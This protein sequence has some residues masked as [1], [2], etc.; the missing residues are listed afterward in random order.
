MRRASENSSASSGK[1]SVAT[2]RTRDSSSPRIIYRRR[3]V[4]SDCG[5]SP[6]L[7]MP[8][9]NG[10]NES[11]NELLTFE[12]FTRY[13]NENV[14]IQITDVRTKLE[15]VTKQVDGNAM[16]IRSIQDE[17]C[18]LKSGRPPPGLACPARV[19][20]ADAERYDKSR[21]SLRVWPIPG[22]DSAKI[23]ESSGVFIHS[24]LRVPQDEMDDSKIQEIKRIRHAG[25]KFK[26]EALIVFVDLESRDVVASYARNLSDRVDSAGNPTA[27][28]RIDIPSHLMGTFKLLENH[29]RQLRERYGPDF[30]RHVR[31]GDT[32]KSLF[33]NI[34]L[35]SDQVWTR[36]S[37]AF[38]RSIAS[39]YESSHEARSKYGPRA[40]SSASSNST[41]PIIYGA[42]LRRPRTDH[43]R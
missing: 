11:D 22:S 10:D 8:A 24:T 37:P 27:G 30:K 34:R 6:A 15:D 32:E 16:D 43:P 20:Y 17:L 31:F 2:K 33:L 5:A 41:T 9:V 1:R 13:M 18:K 7:K 39:E 19:G 28:L 42:S 36:I 21:R 4:D 38:A 12:K 35:P 14:I 3:R 26:D 29:G 23:W 25:G 40:A